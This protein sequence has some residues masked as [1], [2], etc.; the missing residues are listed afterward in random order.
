MIAHWQAEAALREEARSGHNSLLSRSASS[1][2]NQNY[3][4][5][6]H[7]QMENIISRLHPRENLI[8]VSKNR[9]IRHWISHWFHRAHNFNE[10]P[11]PPTM[12]VLVLREAARNIKA[13]DSYIMC[14]WMDNG[15]ILK[16]QPQDALGDR[17]QYGDIWE[18][19][20]HSITP[21]YPDTL[22]RP[23]KLLHRETL[24]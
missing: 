15:L 7:T 16:I 17:L 12:R 20:I 11:L 24:F 4:P 9:S 10:Y 6:N 3:L 21:F 23:L 2:S 22:L 5:F 14:C 19:D 18:A 8:S 13:L 1:L